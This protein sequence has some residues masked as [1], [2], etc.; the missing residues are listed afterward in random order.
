MRPC[1]ALI[2][3]L[4]AVLALAGWREQAV[5][6]GIAAL[7]LLSCAICLIG[8]LRGQLR[9]LHNSQE[10]LMRQ[11]VQLARLADDVKSAQIELANKSRELETTLA[12]M[13]QGLMMIDAGGR[14]VV[15][16]ARATELLGLPADLMASKPTYAEALACYWR[17]YESGRNEL[18]LQE[19]LRARNA[20]DRPHAFEI[21][22]PNGRV[23][24]GRNMPL[25]GGGA[26]RT[27]TDITERKR[28]E[29]RIKRLARQDSLT[30]LANRTGF[31]EK[32]EEA[33]MLAAIDQRGLAVLFLDLDHFKQVN[34]TRGHDVGD[35]LLIEVARRMRSAVGPNDTVGR[36]GGDEFAIILRSPDIPK[37]ARVLAENL[38]VSLAEPYLIDNQGSTIGVSIGIA[39]YP[40]N[41]NTI[42][43]LLQNADTAVYAAKHSGRNTYRFSQA[44]GTGDSA[45]DQTDLAA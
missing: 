14:I 25:A 4:A 2:L 17:L 37:A 26:V 22:H 18:S 11:N 15:C 41:A 20:F 34:D 44:N 45:A 43:A 19:Y 33:A 21:A 35:R 8:R 31:N 39:L 32:L 29:E 6:T 1:A 10:S 38:V 3:V 7:L 9:D 13:D 40:E 12:T 28:A 16:N 36:L 42:G 5:A 27:Y 23:I 30:Q 24:E